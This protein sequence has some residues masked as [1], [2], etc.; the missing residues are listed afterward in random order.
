MNAYTGAKDRIAEQQR[1]GVLDEANKLKLKDMQRE[2]DDQTFLNDAAKQF[3][4]PGTQFNPTV[5]GRPAQPG[6][7]NTSGYLDYVTQNRPQLGLKMRSAFAKDTPFS[8][9]DPGS[10]TP[11]SIAQFAKTQNYGDLRPRTKLE[12]VNGVWSDPYTGSTV[13]VGPQDP[14]KPFMIGPGGR[15]VPNTEY[16]KFEIGKAGAGAARTN[17]AV[18][19]EK[20]LLTTVA[21]GLGKQL[22]SGLSEAK[23]ARGVIGT[24]ARIKELASSGNVIT[25]PLADP[26]VFWD[27][28]SSTLGVAGRD[29]NERLSN[30]AAL[31]QTLA[32]TE[33][34]AAQS[35]KGQ[36]QWTEAERVILKRAAAGD[37]NMTPPELVTLSGAMDKGA[38]MRIR[39]HKEQVKRLG[40]LPNAAQL[41]PFYNVDEPP[42]MDGGAGDGW[43]ITPKGQ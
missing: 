12:N 35:N 3:T 34:E 38:R 29:T 13:R 5:P 11:E 40:E 20:S 23:S 2:Y 33:L 6:G 32:K 8:K 43:S 10:F 39:A 7:F 1:Q 9:I 15:I 41:V 27:R 26:R 25:G 31:V 14:N 18:N 16:Q 19:T 30:T 17:V 37:I 36:G 42:E 24:A 22:D 4:I 28:M 21:E